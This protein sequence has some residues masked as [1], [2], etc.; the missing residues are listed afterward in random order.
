MPEPTPTGPEQRYE[1]REEPLYHPQATGTIAPGSQDPAEGP[2]NPEV[3][4][5]KSDANVRGIVYFA[6]GLV[7]FA[8]AAHLFL[9]WLHDGLL[10]GE[11]AK[12]PKATPISRER[13]VFPQNLDKVPGPLLQTDEVRDYSEFRAQEEAALNNPKAGMPIREAMRLVADPK[14]AEAFGVRVRPPGEAGK[15]GK[16]EATGGEKAKK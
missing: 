14:R 2:V 1:L 16:G 10:Q 13:P 4:H 9:A 3:R 7:A 15:K 11:K 8:V 5:E 6:L 12:E